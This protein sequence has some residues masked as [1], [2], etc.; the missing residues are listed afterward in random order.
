MPKST[1]TISD[2]SP[3]EYGSELLA[4]ARR[5]ARAWVEIAGDPERVLC[6]L[7]FV[8]LSDKDGHARV[9]QTT[10]TVGA[11]ERVLDANPEYRCRPIVVVVAARSTPPDGT[12]TTTVVSFHLLEPD[13]AQ[14]V[15]CCG[16]EHFGGQLEL[17]VPRIAGP[18]QTVTVP[19]A[20]TL[21]P[22]PHIAPSTAV[23]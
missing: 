12:G 9:F 16:V 20:I 21:D 1:I 19:Y 7:H 15:H 14:A 6:D 8:L 23:H 18:T 4:K 11:V 17:G 3:S 10:P 2:A 5:L 22:Q 13:G